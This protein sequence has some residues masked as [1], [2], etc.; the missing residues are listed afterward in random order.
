MDISTMD[1]DELLMPAQV[2][3]LFRVH[4]KTVT[5]WARAGKLEARRT[6]GGHRRYRVGDVRSVLPEQFE[7]PASD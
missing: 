5:R 6:L 2:A 7:S 4:P 3:A 1:D